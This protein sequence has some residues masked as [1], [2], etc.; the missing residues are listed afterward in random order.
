VKEANAEKETIVEKEEVKEVETVLVLT[1]AK[2]EKDLL[3]MRKVKR[4]S[5]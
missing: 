1:A 5:L 4:V 3:A 2:E